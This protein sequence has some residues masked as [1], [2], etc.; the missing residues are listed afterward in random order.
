M[1]LSST[2]TLAFMAFVSCGSGTTRDLNVPMPTERVLVEAE[3]T[4]V[5]VITIDGVMWQDVY[6]PHGRELVPNLW[7]EAG[8][9]GV[10]LGAPGHGEQLAASGPNFVSLPGYT[11]LFEGKTH[12]G[13]TSNFCNGATVPTLVDEVRAQHALPDDVAVFASWDRIALAASVV[14]NDVVMSAG[15]AQAQ[16][17]N[18][19]LDTD[20]DT[21]SAYAMGRGVPSYPGWGDYRPDRYTAR[22]ALAYFK[23]HQPSFMYVGFGDTDEYAHKGQRLRYEQALQQADEFIG[24]IFNEL[25]Q[26]GE[27]GQRTFVIVTTDHGRAHNFR[28]HG[29]AY[30]ESART[31][32]FALGGPAATGTFTSAP[33][34][35]H[36]A[37]IAPTIR[38]VVGLPPRDGSDGDVMTELLTKQ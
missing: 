8:A 13:C 27:R 32:L 35:R 6:G 14:N 36:I 15:S 38:Y 2:L 25:A 30:P 18:G 26:M 19:P 23:S 12:T 24:R 9:H 37:D 20:P 4:P 11:E 21:H 16:G 22:L 7:R 5:I 29:G 28:D 10:A 34:P 31:W 33:V 17:D 1:R 3:T